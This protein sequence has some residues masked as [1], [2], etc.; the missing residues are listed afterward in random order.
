MGAAVRKVL[1]KAAGAF[2]HGGL[3]TTEAG[4]RGPLAGVV[5]G[6]C[7]TPHDVNGKRAPSITAFLRYLRVFFITLLV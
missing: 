1:A 3:Q 6:Q 7:N 4:V 5:L 2:R